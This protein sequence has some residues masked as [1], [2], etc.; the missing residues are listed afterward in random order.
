MAAYLSVLA[1]LVVV[2]VLL[3]YLR[4]PMQLHPQTPDA[5]EPDFVASPHFV[6]ARPGFVFTTRE[7]GTGYYR[8]HPP[9]I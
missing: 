8:D 4:T 6:G 9:M 5:H 2:V 1:A 7:R 3:V